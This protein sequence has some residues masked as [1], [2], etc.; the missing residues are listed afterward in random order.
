MKN[1]TYKMKGIV[2]AEGPLQV[3]Y[4]DAVPGD[5]GKK[6]PR[7]GPELG[8]SNAYFPST[9]LRGALR[10]CMH[11]VVLRAAKESSGKEKPFDLA[12]HFM[13]AQGVDISDKVVAAKN[14]DGTID[15]CNNLRAANPMLSMVGRWK[16]PSKLSVGSL[17][18]TTNGCVSSFG[19]GTR[20]MMFERNRALIDEIELDQVDR[21][22]TILIEQSQSSED[23]GKVK[24]EIREKKKLLKIFD[25]DEKK[26]IFEEIGQLEE[27]IKTI[28]ESKT[29][30]KENIR[31]P[32]DP[33]EVFSAGTE[34]DHKMVITQA[35][36]M[37]MGLFLATLREF[38]RYPVV[39]GKVSLGCGEISGNWQITH[40][41]I[42]Q[43]S[44]EV[45]GAVSFNSDGFSLEGVE[46]QEAL[47]LW[48]KTKTS[49]ED[50]GIDFREYLE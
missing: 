44:P 11:Q 32:L 45:V 49:L 41:D 42:D 1:K 21:L 5:K 43:D 14:S 37:E 40:W 12:N 50:A 28:K 6:L 29:E 8:D 31:R 48:D 4:P 19:G 22:K 35:S 7:N 9:S 30:S 16:L 26:K 27:Q 33:V 10:H 20:G 34:F 38:A 15:F 17:Y 23:I 47:D 2:K 46:L 36:Q 25:G 3:S 39:G 18:P 24:K 13:L